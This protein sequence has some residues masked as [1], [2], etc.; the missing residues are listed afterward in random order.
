MCC[1]GL[2]ADIYINLTFLKQEFI[3]NTDYITEDL[4]PQIEE[5]LLSEYV[6]LRTDSIYNGGRFSVNIKDEMI[7]KKNN[8]N[9][10]LIQ[11]TIKLETSAEYINTVR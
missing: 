6:W 7:D 11:Y 3:I 5:L 4:V 2:V 9:D 10:K 8:L 1:V